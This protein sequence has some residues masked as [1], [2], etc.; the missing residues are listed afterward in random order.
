M[1][2]RQIRHNDEDSPSYANILPY[3]EGLYRH[4]IDPH[5]R[6]SGVSELDLYSLRVEYDLGFAELMSNTA[7][8]RRYSNSNLDQ[9]YYA[10][11]DPAAPVTLEIA[12]TRYLNKQSITSQELRLTSKGDGPFKW[13]L[14]GIY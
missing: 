11:N 1:Y 10:T 2:K 9:I 4:A 7:H 5:G 3:E 6:T 12:N 14:G 13:V 8:S